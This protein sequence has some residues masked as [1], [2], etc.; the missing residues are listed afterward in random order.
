[1]KKLLIVGLGVV[2]MGMQFNLW[3]ATCA[4]EKKG[5]GYTLRVLSPGPGTV[6]N[7][8]APFLLQYYDPAQSFGIKINVGLHQFKDKKKVAKAVKS[9]LHQPNTGNV[10]ITATDLTQ[11]GA[12]AT[13]KDQYFLRV[14]GTGN[15]VIDSECFAFAPALKGVPKEAANAEQEGL[16][17]TVQ[18]YATQIAV[19]TKEV[20]ALKERLAGTGPEGQKLLTNIITK[21]PVSCKC[22][23]GA[24]GLQGPK[25]DKGDKGD[26]GPINSEWDGRIDY[27]TRAVNGFINIHTAQYDRHTNHTHAVIRNFGIVNGIRFNGRTSLPIPGCSGVD[28]PSYYPPRC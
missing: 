20:A 12:K 21:E 11:P 5:K 27:L 6:I 28:D 13:A 14:S 19:L 16:Q 22:G 8:S 10:L 17:L 24:R 3:A 18:A 1:M 9:L 7:K 4:T 2:L 23:R 25:G 15:L 26:V